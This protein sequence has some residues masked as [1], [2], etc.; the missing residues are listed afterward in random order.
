M[1]TKQQTL[2]PGDR[3]MKMNI[4]AAALV[5]LLASASAQT[6]PTLQTSRDTRIGRIELD[7]GF[8]SKE[9]VIEAL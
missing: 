3:M 9:A 5:G 4:F 8:P 7:K 2:E 1:K 6:T